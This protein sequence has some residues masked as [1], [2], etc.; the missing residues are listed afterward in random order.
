LLRSAAVASAA[1]TR[2]AD[3]SPHSSE[4]RCRQ[5]HDI[6]PLEAD[7]PLPFAA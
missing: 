7:T 5:R 2:Y 4:R 1:R 3:A 6:T